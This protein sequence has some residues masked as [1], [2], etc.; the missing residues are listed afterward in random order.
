LIA[1]PLLQ[2]KLYLSH[3]STAPGRGAYVQRARLMNQLAKGLHG[4]LTLI[5]APAG[6]G[7]STLLA[8]WIH[9][10]RVE[11]L[12]VPALAASPLTRTPNTQPPTFC[13]LSLDASDND[14]VR[15]WTY[16][17]AALQT[18]AAELGG[19]ALG[20]LQA[21]QSP[22]VEAVLTLLLNDLAGLPHPC[23]LILDDYQALTFL[24]DH[25]PD[26]LHLMISS[27]SD[28]PLP[29]S[30]LRA[31]QQLTEIRAADMCFTP[32]EAATFFKEGMGLQLTRAEVT[33]LES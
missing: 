11:A 7:K 16:V 13:W 12:E 30:R 8:E 4:K 10:F 14:P 25:L 27:R 5:S 18:V 1:T 33:A 24:L 26:S 19:T 17:I 31:C 29:L 32:D 9:Q 28:P 6:F 15:F 20:A 22:P 2:T 21:P 23:I 3:R